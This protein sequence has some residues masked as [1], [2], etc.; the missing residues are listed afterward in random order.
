MSLNRDGTIKSLGGFSSITSARADE[1]RAGRARSGNQGLHTPAA[2]R[3]I[4]YVGKLCLL[5]VA[6]AFSAPAGE[7][8]VLRT[9]FL[10][11]ADR[12]E[13]EGS[14]IRL[15]SNQGVI[16]LDASAVVGFEPAASPPP[17]APPAGPT[18]K[19]PPPD[20]EALLESAARRY[21]V[22]PE[23]IRLV[24][25]VAK[26]ESGYRMDA[27]SPKGALG[28]MQ[29]MPGT[30]QELKADPRDPKQNADA[31]ARYLRD[32][33]LKYQEHPYQLRMA[34]AA[35]NAG[36]GAVD[37]HKG[38]PPY[39]ET[40]QYVEKVIRHFRD[41]QRK[42]ERQALGPTSPAHPPHLAEAGR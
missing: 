20:P 41:A 9:G 5:A 40:M 16:E 25:S 19:T 38:V 23:F 42:P 1:F 26:V 35:Y 18:A 34:L 37:R 29:L 24:R 6:L 21:G 10:L 22:N 39:P 32:L 30:A 14:K 33:L 7:Y 4:A 3:V 8:A 27:V 36:P 31:G 28:L 13:I 11:Y 2:C 15:Y 12:H 17:A